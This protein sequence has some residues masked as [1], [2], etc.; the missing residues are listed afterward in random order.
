MIKYNLEI[1]RAKERFVPMNIWIWILLVIVFA[2]VVLL[3]IGIIDGNRYVVRRERFTLQKLAKPCRFVMV[4]DLHGK[5]YGKENE[6]VIA[7]IRRANPDFVVI[8]GDLVTSKPKAG[9]EAGVH[10]VKELSRDYKIYYAMGN[11]ETK[12]KQ[13]RDVFGKR[14]EEL[15]Q[16][17]EH[18]NVTVLEDVSCDIPEWNICMTG[19]EL[20][21][22][23]FAR[24]KKSELSQEALEGHIGIAKKNMCNILLAHN[25]NYFE[26]YA[27]WGADLVLAGHVHGG[28][29][30]LPVLGG[31]ISPSLEI[32]PKY[33]GGIFRKK[34]AAMLLG[35][36]MGAHTIPLRFFNPAELYVIT[37]DNR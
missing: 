9:I 15:M 11:H 22:T 3:T 30:K 27:D 21:R 1:L 2:G 35:R 32:F 4:S 19:L 29:M 18:P 23:Y 26:A 33:D 34:E 20:E 7:D 6:K 14:F 31:V 5:V 25:P 8:V 17:I 13:K 36:G 12:L 16:A 37:L 24:L 10:F 28:I